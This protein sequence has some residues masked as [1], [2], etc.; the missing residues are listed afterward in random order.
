MVGRAKRVS[1][2]KKKT[3]GEIDRNDQKGKSTCKWIFTPKK[4]NRELIELSL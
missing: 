1:A 2:L 3:Q 4:E